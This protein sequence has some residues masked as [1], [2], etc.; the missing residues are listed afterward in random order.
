M[1]YALSML[2]VAVSLPLCAPAIADNALDPT[3]SSAGVSLE[4]GVLD[5]EITLAT[6][7]PVFD[8]NADGAVGG[9]N[10]HIQTGP[11]FRGEVRVL[12]GELDF[13]TSVGEVEETTTFAEGRGTLGMEAAGGRFYSGAGITYHTTDFSGTDWNTTTLYVP[14]GFAKSSAVGD[15]WT[16][17]TTIEGR[18]SVAGEEELDDV[19]AVGD[20]TFD[21]GVGYGARFAMTFQHDSGVSIGAFIETVEPGDTDEEFGALEAEEISNSTA[22]VRVGWS[23]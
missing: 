1:K 13:D 23:F 5:R 22:G 14:V 6:N 7:Q 8:V 17:R 19:P 12:S 11:F 18:V 9:V 16:A 21:H 2:T 3:T 20:V 4:V 10:A 15:R